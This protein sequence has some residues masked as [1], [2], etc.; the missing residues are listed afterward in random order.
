MTTLERSR[1]D[2]LDAMSAAGLSVVGLSGFPPNLRIDLANEADRAAA[3]AQAVAWDWSDE[4]QILRDASDSQSSAKSNYTGT[5]AAAR[6][7]RAMMQAVLKAYN[8]V[9][10]AGFTWDPQS[11]ANNASAVFTG[12]SVPGAK[13]RD[14]VDV[15]APYD[16]SGFIVCGSVT[17]ADTVAVRIV[18]VSGG[19]INL[20]SGVWGVAVWRPTVWQMRDATNFITTAVNAN[21]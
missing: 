3:E 9:G 13:F 10:V 18:N 16:V 12:I 8:P 5:D 4:A 7:L 6:V 20:P 14:S 2:L 17:A 1:A 21:A 11:L 15:G 19:T